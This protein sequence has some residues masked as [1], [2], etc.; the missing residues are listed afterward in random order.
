[1]L[2]SDRYCFLGGLSQIKTNLQ[3]TADNKGV[4]ESTFHS[5]LKEAIWTKSKEGCRSE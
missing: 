3:G 4:N 1:M 5:R 2:M